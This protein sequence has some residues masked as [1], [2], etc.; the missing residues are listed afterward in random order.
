MIKILMQLNEVTTSAIWN[1]ELGERFPFHLLS[2]HSCHGIFCFSFAKHKR[3]THEWPVEDVCLWM[4]S[5]YFQPKNVNSSL[6]R[7]RICHFWASTLRPN[8][9]SCPVPTD[10]E[11]RWRSEWTNTKEAPLLPDHRAGLSLWLIHD[12]TFNLADPLWVKKRPILQLTRLKGDR[13]RTKR[14]RGDCAEKLFLK[15]CIIATTF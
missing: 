13:P 4:M 1:N 11:W 6:A 7:S 12:F 15:V 5:D 14:G 8:I 2:L 3:R 9:L 10:I